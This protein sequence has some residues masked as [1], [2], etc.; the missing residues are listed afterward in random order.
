G[1]EETALLLAGMLGGA[2]PV[3]KWLT[4]IQPDLAYRV[5]T[6][7]GAACEPA[8]MTALY[9]PPGG[10]R[11]SPYAVAEWRRLNHENDKRPGVSLRADGLPDMLWCNVPAGKFLYG[12]DKQ[13]HELTYNFRIAKYPVTYVQFRAFIESGEFE[14]PDW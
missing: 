9:E 10:A 2:T 1:W 3:V 11:R 8:A 4:A 6:E 5:A 7:S 14:N 12:A 13:E